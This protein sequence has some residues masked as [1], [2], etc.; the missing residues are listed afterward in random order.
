MTW[1][2]ASQKS[3]LATI[4]RPAVRSVELEAT[5]R[6]LGDTIAISDQAW[7]EPSRLP[8]WTRAHVVT[9]LAQNA[10]GFYRA[11]ESISSGSPGHMYE[12]ESIRRSSFERGSE[13]SALDLQIDLDA[14]AGRLNR[15]FM[16]LEQVPHDYVLEL[17]PGLHLL[18][19]LIPLARLAEVVVHHLDLDCGF[20]LGDISDQLA[21]MLLQWATHLYRIDSPSVILESSTGFRGYLGAPGGEVIRGSNATLFGWVMGRLRPDDPAALDLP[22]QPEPR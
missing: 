2:I 5:Q 9:H 8:G 7:Q 11:L 22:P 17:R 1:N 13:R 14:S 16:I 19:H 15:K 4:D 12:A 20:Y 18:A 6:L 21:S 10:N 3:F